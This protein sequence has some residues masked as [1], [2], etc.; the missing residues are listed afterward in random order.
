MNIREHIERHKQELDSLIF[1][2]NN[3]R[4]P[5]TEEVLSLLIHD[6]M[7][8]ITRLQHKERKQ[9]TGLL[10]SPHSFAR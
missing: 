3:A 10:A 7:V 8:E 5:L 9:R 4:T 6:T 2:Y 1:G